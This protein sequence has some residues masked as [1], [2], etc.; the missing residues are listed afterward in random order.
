MADETKPGTKTTEFW[1]SIIIEA[2][3]L[4]I[5][6]YGVINKDTNTIAI[7]AGLAGVSVAG[8][9]LSRGIAKKE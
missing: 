8:Y 9:T 1:K 7:G 5:I 4:A 2:A 3:G 6:V